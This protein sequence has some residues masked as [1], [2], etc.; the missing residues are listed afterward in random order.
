MILE[1]YISKIIYNSEDSAYA[2]FVIEQLDGDEVAVGNVPGIAE[3]MY[4]QAEG[5]YVHHPQYD[6]QFKI[7]SCELSMPTDI[8]GIARF[9]GSGIIKGIGEVLA[10][11]IVKKFGEDTLRIIEKEPERLAEVN[12]ISE[13]IANK[14]A[15]SYIENKSYR[16]V[17]MY[18]GKYGIKW[19]E[20]PQLL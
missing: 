1:G 8:E 4:I 15:V 19:K 2:V 10:K 11:R 5:E 6:L 12:G 16:G 3:G 14:I 20:I 18:L 7:S 9:L 17:I 13:R